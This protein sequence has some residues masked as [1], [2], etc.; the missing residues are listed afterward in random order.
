LVSAGRGGK[1]GEGTLLWA[2]ATMI[3]ELFLDAV[4]VCEFQVIFWTMVGTKAWMIVVSFRSPVCVSLISF[5]HMIIF[6]IKWN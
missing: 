4:R 2:V 6:I 5:S 3:P 1:A